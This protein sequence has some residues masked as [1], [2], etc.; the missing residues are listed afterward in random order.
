MSDEVKQPSHYMLTLPSGAKVEC[1]DVIHGLGLSYNMGN[2][3][4]YIWRCGR[5][6]EDRL[7]DLRKALTYLEFEI[8]REVEYSH[9]DED[10]LHPRITADGEDT[11]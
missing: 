8:Q 5:K 1:I 9:E 10:R 2:A 3:L 6:T 4:K 11:R 7:T